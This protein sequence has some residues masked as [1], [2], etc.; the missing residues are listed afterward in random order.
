MEHS[1]VPRETKACPCVGSWGPLAQGWAEA[2]SGLEC[3]W[4][5]EVFFFKGEEDSIS[6]GREVRLHGKG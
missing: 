2:A 6:A 5:M 1:P 3:P 4:L